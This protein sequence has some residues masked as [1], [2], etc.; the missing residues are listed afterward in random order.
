M[1]ILYVF[2]WASFLAYDLAP[3]LPNEQD[4]GLAWYWLPCSLVFASQGILIFFIF[5][6]KRDIFRE[7]SDK[8]AYL[9]R[10]LILTLKKY[11]ET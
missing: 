4:S 1:G 7:L 2:E 3:M 5:T 6:L 8:Y 10:K 11:S 9:K